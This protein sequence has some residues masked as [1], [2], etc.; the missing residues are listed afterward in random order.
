MQKLISQL[1]RI[2]KDS[3]KILDII[4]F[5]S[6]IKEKEKPKDIDLAILFKEEDYNYIDKINLKIK[7]IIQK[8]NLIPHI[9]VLLIDNIF[10]EPL[11]LTLLHEGFSIKNKIYISKSLKTES[12]ILIIYSLKNLNYSKKTLFGYALKGRTGKKGLLYQINGK[13]IGRNSILIPTNKLEII[14]D[15]LN[16][17]GIK[18][19]IERVLIIG[20]HVQ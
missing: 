13:T 6:Y 3:N 10:K 11:Y 14:K 7:N 8:Y 18:Y 20:T 1:K 2:C 12:C 16:L 9:Q 19:S 15:F 4:L 5:G 17:W